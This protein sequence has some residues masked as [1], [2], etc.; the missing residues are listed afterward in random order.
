MYRTATRSSLC[1]G[2]VFLFHYELVKDKYLHIN[3]MLINTLQ[4]NMLKTDKYLL[5][6]TSNS[7]L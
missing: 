3:D 5:Y 2:L 4:I 1:H 6:S 7:W